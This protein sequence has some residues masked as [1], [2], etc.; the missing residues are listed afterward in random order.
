MSF[1]SLLLQW[2]QHNARVLPWRCVTSPYRTWVSEVMLQQTQVEAVIPYFERWM[3]KLPDIESLAIA[4][5]QVLLALWEGLGYYG[6]ARNLHRT[7]KQVM[8]VFNG[9]LP[10]N[11]RELNK[12]PGIGPYTAAAIASIAFGENIAAVDGNIRRVYSRYFNVKVPIDSTQGQQII[13]KLAD[14]ALP[15]EN[16]GDFNQALMDLGATIC[17]PKNPK[18]DQCPISPGCLARQQGVQELRPIR[19][20]KKKVPHLTVTAAIIKRED[21]NVLLAQRP[22]GGLLG[23]LW[24]FPGGTLE[25]EDESLEQG[26]SRE[27]QEELGVDILIEAAYGSYNHAY[28]HYKITLHAFLCKLFP[29]QVPRS[30]EG[31]NITWLT[32]DELP[33]FPMGKVDRLIA[34]QLIKDNNN[35]FLSN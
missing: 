29:D 33:N 31:Q 9:K 3:S 17:R 6:R 35:E 20:P 21:G 23:G 22:H 8:A 30:M 24:E 18:C 1:A 34:T 26:L 28:T 5:E 32:L 4:D 16:A 2:Y 19:L 10:T 12:L 25:E 7:A 27:I 11:S 15:Q 14:E 13:A